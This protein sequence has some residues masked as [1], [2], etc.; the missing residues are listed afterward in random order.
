MKKIIAILLCFAVI[1]SGLSVFADATMHK[2]TQNIRVEGVS[3][4]NSQV[5]VCL[6]KKGAGLSD[7]NIG[8]IGQTTA[9]LSGKYAYKFKFDADS[10]SDYNFVIKEGEKDITDNISLTLVQGNLFT[11]D[12][13]V[14]SKGGIK[15]LTDGD[16]A[17]LNARIKNLYGDNNEKFTVVFASYDKDGVLTG[18]SVSGVA[19]AKYNGE[20]DFSYDVSIPENTVKMKAF[21]WGESFVTPLSDGTENE[22]I[23]GSFVYKDSDTVA[24]IGDSITAGVG[25]KLT[26]PMYIEY[27]YNTR[28]PERNISFTNYGIPNDTAWGG[29]NRLSW[30]ILADKV[31]TKA[32]IMFG[33]NDIVWSH[34]SD[35]VTGINQNSVTNSVGNIK[36]IKAELDKNGTKT[37]FITP[38]VAGSSYDKYPY[39]DPAMDLQAEEIEKAAKELNIPVVDWHSY[40]SDIKKSGVN[41]M[42]DNIHPAETG[43]TIMAY[44]F[45]KQQG[46]KQVSEIDIKNNSVTAENA[47]I[48]EVSANG[49]GISFTYKPYSLPLYNSNSYKETERFY[50]ITGG[51]NSETIK[52]DLGDGTYEIKL[53]G[54]TAFT[55]SSNELKKGVNIA[56]SDKNPNLETSKKV[57]ELLC[58][59]E[60]YN[61]QYEKRHIAQMNQLMKSANIDYDSV[62]YSI[63]AAD[64]SYT[65]NVVY[66]FFSENYANKMEIYY[67]KY[68]ACRKNAD[69]D[70]KLISDNRSNAKLLA[71]PVSYKI[72]IIRK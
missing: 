13:T 51:L 64:P 58:S 49:S 16:I 14:S 10:L 68:M 6:V 45:L 50:D 32:T 27:F 42:P 24:F 29:L 8:H 62:D 46:V 26:Y 17:E 4:P 57:Y 40:L 30:D 55:V 25:T 20:T 65:D 33:F 1:F 7:E 34:T 48:S 44:L 43:Q 11:S 63:S 37:V 41:L 12:I 5:T 52:A 35:S 60:M 61:A 59:E 38:T 39:V 70:T 22:D 3:A 53:D 15:T 72:D 67:D 21:V 69:A 18:S 36:K 31:P 9:D 54:K 71:K 28:Y 23:N 47:D 66:K 2:N 19:N 56:L